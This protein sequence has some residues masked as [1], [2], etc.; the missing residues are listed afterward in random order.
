M[1]SRFDKIGVVLGF[2]FMYRKHVGRKVQREHFVKYHWPFGNN[3]GN[4]IIGKEVT[5]KEQII[6]FFSSDSIRLQ[7]SRGCVSPCN[8][9]IE[10]QAN[11]AIPSEA[12]WEGEDFDTFIQRLIH[13]Q[14]A[15]KFFFNISNSS[16]EDPGNRGFRDMIGFFKK[17]EETKFPGSFK[18]HL[19]AETRKPGDFD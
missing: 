19:R 13:N 5:D 11:K 10:G 8:Y 7:R 12:S 6:D 16:F 2:R 1:I 17:L 14:D 3:K 15:G 4:S 18:I 9:C